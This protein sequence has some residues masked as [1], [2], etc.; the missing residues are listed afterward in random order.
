MSVKFEI[1]GVFQ[2][3]TADTTITLKGGIQRVLLQT[4]LASEE[5]IVSVDLL[6]REMWDFDAPDGFVNALQAHV[7][8]VRKWLHSLE[9]TRPDSRLLGHPAGYQLDMDGICLDAT[10]FV[11][12][13]R[14]ALTV[15]ETE[16]AEAERLL[17]AAL[18]MW[19]GPVFGGYAGGPLC[20]AAAGRYEEYRLQ[21]QEAL[22]DLQLLS[23]QHALVLSELR[24]E[25]MSNPL[26]EKFCQQ[27]M[28]ALYR[29]GRQ[30]EALNVYH[31]M[32]RR[33][34]D[35]LGLKP[36][37]SLRTVEQAILEHSPVLQDRHPGRVVGAVHV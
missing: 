13:V 24:E 37:P 36:S 8:R 30:V 18:A 17:R 22:F 23:G 34:Q 21:A 25:H 29:S 27:L 3:C 28:V 1:L 15:K 26:R 10:D 12:T 4:L 33:L 32:R 31:Q 7:S 11:G 19:R 9:P 6:V 2:A 20:Q 5:R 35:D 14:R 16:E